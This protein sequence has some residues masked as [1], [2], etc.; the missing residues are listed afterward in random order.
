MWVPTA[1]AFANASTPYWGNNRTIIAGSIEGTEPPALP[2]Y[3]TD[4][5]SPFYQ[6]VKE[7]YDVSQTLTDEQKAMALF[8]RDVPGATS[9]GHWL[10][11]VQQ[12]IRQKKVSLDKTALA[13]ALTGIAINDGLIACF[14]Y[15]YQNPVVRPI[16]YIREVM[17]HNMWTPFLG[18]PAHPEYVSA[19]SNLSGA[20]AA[21]LEK[22]FGHVGSFTDH[23]YDYLGFA[24]R[25]YTSFTA[26]GEDAAN[27]RL[28]AGIHYRVS[29]I[30]G[31][32]QG[33]KVA[34]NILSGQVNW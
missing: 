34:A 26:I 5:S 21:V 2:A 29:I 13:Y 31:L 23:T 6:M 27:S 19:H 12:T 10:S 11:I 9:P 17:G 4:P 15:K 18:T 3:S 25:T 1:P 28:Y 20:A 16:T 22:L 30:A 7:V 32:N 14:K 8:W 24:P 33:R